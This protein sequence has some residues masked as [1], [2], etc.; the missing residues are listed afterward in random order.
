MAYNK[1]QGNN[2]DEDFTVVI[3]DSNFDQNPQNQG[4]NH[5]NVSLVILSDL[6]P[7]IKTGNDGGNEDRIPSAIDDEENSVSVPQQRNVPK[8]EPKSKPSGTFHWLRS[9]LGGNPVGPVGP[10]GPEVPEAEVPDG[11]DVSKGPDEQQV[12]KKPDEPEADIFHDKDKQLVEWKNVLKTILT[13][14]KEKTVRGKVDE[15]LSS[16][17][18]DRLE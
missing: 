10:D 17:K 7:T 4:S 14:K 5:D 12:P 11:H 3:E 1:Y 16:N 2:K 15:F 18:L 9:K 13:H 6:E 8:T